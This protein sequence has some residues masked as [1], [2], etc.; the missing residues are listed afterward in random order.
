MPMAQE[1]STKASTQKVRQISKK[2]AA[3]HK[4]LDVQVRALAKKL[5]VK[6][7]TEPN[8]DQKKWIKD[9]HSKRGHAYDVTLVKWLR[10]AHG[11][12]FALIGQ[13]RGSTQ[14][15]LVRK[16]SEVANM[17]VLMHQQMLESTGLTTAK[18]F[19]AP[20]AVP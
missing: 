10:F 16:F 14:N 19:P 1:A 6:L 12:I 3:Q 13:V 4:Y 18:S 5:K 9:I 8:A 17:Y 2:M 11:Q 20:P 7:P 15:T